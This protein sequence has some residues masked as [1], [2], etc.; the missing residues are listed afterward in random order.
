M[1]INFSKV[2]RCIIRCPITIILTRCPKRLNSRF[3]RYFCS[4]SHC[5]PKSNFRFIDWNWFNNR[6]VIIIIYIMDSEINIIICWISLISQ[7]IF[8][9]KITKSI[10]TINIILANSEWLLIGMLINFGKVTRYIIG[11]KSAVIIAQSPNRLNARFIRYFC[12]NSHCIPNSNI[13]F[14]NGNRFNNRWVIIIIDIMDSKI[15]VIIFR[16][17][18]ISQYIFYMKIM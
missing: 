7:Y 13:L 18:I 14:I 6:W 3:I 16:I 15:N 1:V 10:S 17:S 4:N 2:T 5:I 12:S 8:Y 9:N 11:D